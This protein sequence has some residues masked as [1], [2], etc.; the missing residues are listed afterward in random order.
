LTRRQDVFWDIQDMLPSQ[1]S[2]DCALGSA[3]AARTLHTPSAVV[4]RSMARGPAGKS[5]AGRG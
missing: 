3:G 5:V 2:L 4:V 1:H